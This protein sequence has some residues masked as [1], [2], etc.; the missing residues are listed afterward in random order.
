MNIEHV[1]SMYSTFDSTSAPLDIVKK[2]KEMGC[3][4]IT[5]TDHDNLMGIEEF[6]SAGEELDVN[7]IPGI[8]FSTIDFEN[9]SHLVVFAKN[10]KGYQK[11]CFALKEANLTIKKI[12]NIKKPIASMET[13]NKFFNG[14]EDVY[15]TTACIQGIVASTLL[16]NMK[17]KK[18]ADKYNLEMSKYKDEYEKCLSAEEEL[19]VIKN[20]IKEL[21]KDITFQNKSTND[22]VY[23]RIDKLKAEIEEL[24]DKLNAYSEDEPQYE[25]IKAKIDKKSEDL[26]TFESNKSK[27]EDIL[28]IIERELSSHQERKAELE[29]IIKETSTFKN[30]YVKNET[31]LKEI[32]YFKEENLYEEAKE[33]LLELKG[34]FKNLFIEIQNHYI[35]EELYVMPILVKLAKETNT[36]LIA[37]NDAHLID[38]SFESIE[39]RRVIRFNYFAKPQITTDADKEMYLKTEEELTKC[40]SDAVGINATKEAIENLK[41]LDDCKVI[42]PKEPHYPKTNSEEF[43]SLL[44]EAKQEKI[45]KGLWN[46]TY[47]ERLNYEIGI[48]KQ[49]GYVDYHLIVRDFCFMGKKLGQIPKAEIK[50]IPEDFNEVDSWLRSKNFCAGIGIGHGRGSAAGSLVC[51]LLGITN[52]DPIKY[53]LLFERFLNP[54]RVS[55]PDIDTD[56]KT[57]LRGTII[58]Y[59]KQKYGENAVC[60]VGTV[61][62]YAAKGAIQMA[63]RE[64]LFRLFEDDKSQEAKEFR[65]FYMGISD[66]IPEEPGAKIIDSV[67]AIRKEYSKNPYTEEIIRNALLLE[68]KASGTG[69]HAGGVV[70]SDNDNINEYVPLCFNEEKQL[71]VTQVDKDKLEEKGLLKMDLLGLKTLDI[72]SDCVQLINKTTGE[73]I[74]LDNIPF[75][76]EVFREIYSKGITNSVFQFE[77]AGM[78]NILTLFKPTCFEDL[79]ILVSMFRPGPKQFIDGVIDVKWGNKELSFLCPELKPILE[80]TYGAIV[81]QEQVMQIFQSLAG[82][83]LGGAD[84]VRRYMSKKKADKLAHEKEAFINGDPERNIKGCVQKGISKE[85]AEKLFEQMEEFSKYAFNKSHA[86]AYAW[87]SYQTAWLKYHYPLQFETAM[88]NNADLDEYEPIFEDC[89]YFG[90]PILPPDINHSSLD[91]TIEKKGIRYG[92]CNI[93]GVGNANVPMFERFIKNSPYKT[94]NEFLLKNVENSGIIEIP[95]KSI[96]E[97]FAKVGVFDSLHPNRNSVIDGFKNMNL[98]KSDS[99]DEIKRKINETEVIY[100][101]AD[102]YS[103]WENEAELLGKIVS[104]NPLANFHNEKKYGC[105]NISELGEYKGNADLMGFVMSAEVAKNFRCENVI[106]LKA[107]SKTGV[108]FKI[109]LQKNLYT[110]YSGELMKSLIHQTFKVNG[111]YNGRNAIYANNLTKLTANI[112]EYA[113]DVKDENTF[114]TV[115]DALNKRG[116]DCFITLYAFFYFYDENGT[117]K[118]DIRKYE[119]D[120]NFVDILKSQNICLEKYNPNSF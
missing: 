36:P 11:I 88:F 22:T 85:V 86:A 83:T 67:D 41:I 82:Y 120:Q 30:K 75:E 112:V 80:K 15:A 38:N 54:E 87:A 32:T 65:K 24:R 66:I 59:L 76:E 13:L 91:F 61:S 19:S 28:P 26:D 73:I 81:Y 45:K 7:T 97:S 29:K 71:W 57:S 116:D 98:N 5:L 43:D 104:D 51:Y 74:D 95:D 89:N 69:I 93:K 62:T 64:L 33:R 44:E 48:I 31:L 100:L 35:D 106:E 21:K 1:H 60:S 6:M 114:K 49:M 10:Y 42:F 110:K 102:K 94:F 55:M 92:L 115:L 4:S 25:K 9:A 2:A 103:N 3:N 37:A 72:M 113:L 39:A 84:T 70:I 16:K 117:S 58:R 118:V 23:K 107:L 53:D 14:C 56:V 109:V 101:P 108:I 20:G 52:I 18:K 68:G 119:V 78:K 27:A 34:I 8:E 79:I 96:I 40:L 12:G 50:N 47:E 46:E 111:Y 63:G 17:L 105:S 77:S 99:F 90:I